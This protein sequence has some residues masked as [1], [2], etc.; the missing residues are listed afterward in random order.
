[1]DLEVTPDRDGNINVRGPLPWYVVATRWAVSL[2][3]IYSHVMWMTLHGTPN[4]RI[5]LLFVPWG[6]LDCVMADWLAINIWFGRY[7]HPLWWRP[8]APE[9]EPE[10]EPE[11]ILIPLA[12]GLRHSRAGD[13]DWVV[14]T[15]MGDR[16]PIELDE[17][18]DLI[19]RGA[20]THR[21]YDPELG[22]TPR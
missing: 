16:P 13:G 15:A 4:L 10:P 7:G 6:V 2:W 21:L 17:N 11:P 22:R 8:P 3:L 19:I 14:H 5:L 20:E 9:P 1:M 18:G 12:P